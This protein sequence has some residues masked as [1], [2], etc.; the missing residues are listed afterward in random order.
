MYLN[1]ICCW[2]HDERGGE[3]EGKKKLPIYDYLPAGSLINLMATGYDKL[4][5]VIPRSDDR[6]IQ[7]SK[8]GQGY[9][10]RWNGRECLKA[11]KWRVLQI[12]TGYPQV[13]LNEPRFRV[14]F[15]RIIRSRDIFKRVRDYG[16]DR[17]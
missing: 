11:E 1:F 9:H 13:G 14:R 16:C 3:G 12:K 10:F 4:P 5:K 2:K 15:G 6:L 7:G 8:L 17:Q